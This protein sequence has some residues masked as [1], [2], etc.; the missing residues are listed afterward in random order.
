MQLILVRHALAEPRPEE[1]GT[2][3][4][5]AL[6]RLTPKGVRKMRGAA[7]GLVIAAPAPQVLATSPLVRA[8]ETAE[9]I[10]EAYDRLVPETVSELKPRAGADA[11][12]AWLRHIPE[13]HRVV[14]VGH[15]PDLSVVAATLL[16]SHSTPIFSFKK[17]AACLIDVP[18]GVTPGIASLQ[19]FLTPRQLRRLV[20][21][22]E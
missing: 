19:W 5:D 21:P 1:G 17:G 13:G 15:E 18:A 2:Q 22:P 14:A 4:D 8:V 16:T 12:I 9:I 6:R 20:E 7:A 10:G 3:N 11:V